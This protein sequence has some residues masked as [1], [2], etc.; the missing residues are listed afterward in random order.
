LD[1]RR[2]PLKEKNLPDLCADRIDYSLR[3]AT[4]HKKISMEQTNKYL[5]N[6]KTIDNI[7][8]FDNFEIAKEYVELFASM[9][10]VWS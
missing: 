9:D 8:I 5:N 10:N 1:D 2:H 3:D 7:R 4:H 6:L